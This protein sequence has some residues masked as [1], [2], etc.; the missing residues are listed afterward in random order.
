M[1]TFRLIDF[2]RYVKGDE[3]NHRQ[4][5]GMVEIFKTVSRS[6]PISVLFQNNS[7]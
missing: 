5:N 1:I 3:K 2:I 7:G 6:T 4:R